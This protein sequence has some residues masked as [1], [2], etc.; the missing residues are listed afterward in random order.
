MRWKRAPHRKAEEVCGV[1]SEDVTAQEGCGECVR[2]R[3]EKVHRTGKL[4]KMCT[5]RKGESAPHRKATEEVC[6]AER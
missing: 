4:R 5:V 3:K 2:C 6:G 1:K